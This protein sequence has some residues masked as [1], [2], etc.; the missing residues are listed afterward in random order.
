MQVAGAKARRF[1]A[2]QRGGCVAGGRM[3]EG[4]NLRAD[5]LDLDRLIGVDR[6][7]ALAAGAARSRAPAG[8]RRSAGGAL[9]KSR[10]PALGNPVGIHG[11]AGRLTE[12]RR[13]VR[14]AAARKGLVESAPAYVRRCATCAATIADDSA[15]RT[16]LICRAT[17]LHGVEAAA[18]G[19]PGRPAGNPTR[20]RLI[21]SRRNER[22][23][24]V[25]RAAARKGLVEPTPA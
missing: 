12:R 1:V 18:A 13:V 10:E 4:R 3:G 6:N 7:A 11:S 23:R 14:R 20:V 25:R 5:I 17:G 2:A 21:E 8:V 19:S 24:V 9:G 16:A 15:A 22:R